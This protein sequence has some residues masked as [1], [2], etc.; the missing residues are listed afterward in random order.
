MVLLVPVRASVGIK[1]YDAISDPC[2]D[3]AH[4]FTNYGS[5]PVLRVGWENADWKETLIKF[6]L[7][8]RPTNFFRIDL[9]FYCTYLD[10]PVA[11]VIEELYF[12]YEWNES[13]IN[14]D[15][16]PDFFDSDTISLITIANTEVNLIVLERYGLYDD[17]SLWIYIDYSEPLIGTDLV[18]ASRES[19]FMSPKIIFSYWVDDSPRIIAVTVVISALCIGSFLGYFIYKKRRK[20]KKS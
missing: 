19:T 3:E 8:G 4:P 1:A 2:D 9:A 17:Y 5:E 14:W 7:S 12:F 16:G 13:S 15:N 18:I 6:D 11:I 10:Y 20:L